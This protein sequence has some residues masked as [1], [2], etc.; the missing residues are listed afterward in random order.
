M[1]VV[2]RS[3]RFNYQLFERIECGVELTGGEA[4]SVRAGHVK[5]EGAHVRIHNGEAILLNCQIFPYE[6]ASGESKPDRTR[7]L[8]LH[9][10]EIQALEQKMKTGRLTLVP[11]AVYT[12]GP[13]VKVEIA[14][15][16]GKRK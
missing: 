6:Y 15:A 13:K 12:K 5:L 9:K 14:L 7:R 10:K 1:R 2:N 8:L 3:A 16:R 4:K 11:T